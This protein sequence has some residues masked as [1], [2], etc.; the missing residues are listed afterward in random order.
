VTEKQLVSECLKVARAMNAYLEVAGQHRADGSGTTV[1]LPDA[2]LYCAGK[3]QPVEFKT[4]KGKLSPGQVLA[5]WKRADQHVH[6]WVIR[7]TAEF[8]DLVN[9]CRR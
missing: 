8:V 1:G 6:T 9:G 4:P 3:C 2:F 7:S 5:Q